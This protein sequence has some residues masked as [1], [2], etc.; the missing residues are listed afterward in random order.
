MTSDAAALA[1]EIDQRLPDEPRG[2]GIDAP[3]RLV[4]DEDAGRRMISR[5]TT[6][7]CRLPPESLRGLRIALRPCARR[8]SAT[9]ARGQAP[10]RV[11]AATKPRAADLA[12][13]VMGEERV[14]AQAMGRRRRMAEPLLGH[15]GGAEPPARVDA[16]APDRR[17]RRCATAPAARRETLAGERREQL[18][19]AVAGDAGDADDLARPDRQVDLLQGHAVRIAGGQRQAAHRERLAAG[20]VRAHAAADL[21]DLAA[22]HQGRDGAGARLARVERR[23][24]PA[25]AQDGGAVRHR[26]RTSSSLCEM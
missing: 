23:D 4:D 24:D 12:G 21:A 20:G 7:F 13:R 22:D 8:S 15:E 18:A 2:A 14:L 1:G 10:R 3:G 26:R 6:N 17:G 9:I 11:R 16:V 25:V 5:P 19:L